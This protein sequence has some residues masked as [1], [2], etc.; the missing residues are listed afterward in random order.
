MAQ[1]A[2]SEWRMIGVGIGAGIVVL[3]LL[4][5]A[6]GIG[7][8]LGQSD[9]RA[10]AAEAGTT[11]AATTQES[12]A[13]GTG[14]QAAAAGLALFTQHCG[15]CHTLSGA[16]TSGTVGPNLDDLAPSKEQVLAAIQNG[17]LGTGTMPANLVQGAEAEQVAEAVASSAGG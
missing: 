11:P 7:Y 10:S 3:L 4:A 14:G 17:G 16:G 1:Q 15:S 6:F 8:N 2:K 5:A 12:G 9:E 13:T